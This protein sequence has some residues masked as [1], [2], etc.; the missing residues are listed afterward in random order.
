MTISAFETNIS[1]VC[2]SVCGANVSYITSFLSLLILCGIEVHSLLSFKYEAV[3]IELE[4]PYS[5]AYIVE[6]RTK[7][8][9]WALSI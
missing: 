1:Y 5:I 7:S 8:F 9:S 2:N 4:S 6:P 3:W